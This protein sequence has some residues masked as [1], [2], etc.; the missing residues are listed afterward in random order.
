MTTKGYIL[1]GKWVMHISTPNKLIPI[2]DKVINWRYAKYKCKSFCVTHISSILDWNER[3]EYVIDCSYEGRVY[4]VGKEY[5]NDKKL[6]VYKSRKILKEIHKEFIC[7]YLRTPHFTGILKEY[8]IGGE[9]K[10][11]YIIKN[12][13][14]IKKLAFFTDYKQI[15]DYK[16]N[17]TIMVNVNDGSKRVMSGIRNDDR[18]INYFRNGTWEYHG[19][20]IYKY[21]TYFSITQYKNGRKHG[22]EYSLNKGRSNMMW[23][24]NNKKEKSPQKIWVDKLRKHPTI[25]V[26]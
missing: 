14:I 7:N 13:M 11:N 2:S 1:N 18:S 8:D 24:N 12:G 3:R 21:N 10:F 22:L 26:Y 5:L 6:E 19:T 25:I 20:Q 16:K 17:K 23:W 4:E 15:F 9:M